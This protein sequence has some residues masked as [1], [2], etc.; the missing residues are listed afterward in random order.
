MVAGSGLTWQTLDLAAVEAVAEVTVVEAADTAAGEAAAEVDTEE[1]AVA[2]VTR[3]VV[4]MVEA[5]VTEGGV[6]SSCLGVIACITV[7]ETQS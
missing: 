7:F 1:V 6:V 2:V 4:D 3:V 5:A